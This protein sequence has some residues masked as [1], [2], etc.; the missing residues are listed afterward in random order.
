M[1]MAL[2]K[3]NSLQNKSETLEIVRGKVDFSMISEK[4]NDKNFRLEK[5]NIN[6][7]NTPFHRDRM[8]RGEGVT[9][10]VLEDILA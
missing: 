7:F 6:D 10:F 1:T 5:F 8:S 4:K 3:V 2:L 9:V